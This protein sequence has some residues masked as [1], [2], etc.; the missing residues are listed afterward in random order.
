MFDIFDSVKKNCEQLA[1]KVS[2]GV[3]T[4]QKVIEPVENVLSA[5]E[6]LSPE[7]VNN[8]LFKGV[9][10]F[11][12]KAT[13]ALG[14]VSDIEDVAKNPE[15]IFWIA[16]KYIGL[17]FPE[18]G[19]AIAGLEMANSVIEMTT[20]INIE[21]NA[22]S[23]IANEIL[24]IEDPNVVDKN[25]NITS[26]KNQDIDENCYVKGYNQNNTQEKE[27]IR[28]NN[29]QSIFNEPFCDNL[30]DNKEIVEKFL[31][32]LIISKP[33]NLKNNLILMADLED[34]EDLK[35]VINQYSSK[36]LNIMR[37]D[38]I[39]NLCDQNNKE[40]ILPENTIER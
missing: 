1:V 16:P 22:Q 36:D 24:H 23:Y 9:S 13:V 15:H 12:G 33:E 30:L 5:I 10:G 8:K 6:N 29:L 26:L 19:L 14:V 38:L 27:Y 11:M 28:Q 34:L 32:V 18:V 7:I 31:E 39:E 25:E 20:G 40:I 4:I 2:E 37:Q 21:K 17:A 3:T 35:L